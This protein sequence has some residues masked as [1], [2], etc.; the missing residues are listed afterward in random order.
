M[1]VE[2]DFIRYALSNAH[3]GNRTILKTDKDYNDFKGAGMLGK[4]F[5]MKKDPFNTYL[6]SIEWSCFNELKT[7][8]SDITQKIAV[9]GRYQFFVSTH[10]GILFENPNSKQCIDCFLILVK[11]IISGLEEYYQ[12]LP[13]A[14][15]WGFP[16]P[17]E[18]D[19]VALV[20]AMPLS[21]LQ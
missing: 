1:V 18:R 14:H 7:D 20:S 2:T 10:K 3:H 8:K 15:I 21:G 16:K 13:F 12:V 17:S 5:P 4:Y 6:V 19:I 11:R 9:I